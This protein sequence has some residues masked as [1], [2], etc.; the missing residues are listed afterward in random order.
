[1]N[2]QPP[3]VFQR[4][5]GGNAA[6]TVDQFQSDA[7]EIVNEPEPVAAR[8]TLFVLS[9]FVLF[10]LLWS[11]FA[12]IDRIVTARGRVVTVAPTI[13]VQPFES[14]IVK[15][16][17]VRVGDAVK[18][19][20]VLA[21]LDP[22]FALA[23]VGQIEGRVDSLD[24]VIERLQAEHAGRPH[25]L[26]PD[27]G[28]DHDRL[29]YSIWQERQ[30]QYQAQMASYQE[31]ISSATASISARIKER[32]HLRAR[33][34][35]LREVE[36]MRSSLESRQTGSR[37]NV[38]LAR[39]AR[40]DVELS[41]QIAE[42]AITETRH[43]MAALEAERDVFSRG[44]DSALVEELVAKKDERD[45]LNEQL[46]KARRLKDMIELRTP[47]DAV[48]LDVAARS[49]GSV[50][51]SAEPLF[52]LVP[53]DAVLEVEAAVEARQ[54]GYIAVGDPVQIKLEAYPYQEHGMLEGRITTI[55]GDAFSP[56][57]GSEQAAIGSFYRVRVEVTRQDLRNVP[58]SFQL[59]P[60]MPLAAEIK[61]GKRSVISYL[62]R[63]ILR[64]MDE[65]MREP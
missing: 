34:D 48:V 60:G 24:A 44:W 28:N 8:M 11:V 54:L 64:G 3:V 15:S 29:Q 1:M 51:N 20:D 19:N 17:D 45:S 21:R 40:I 55:S 62:L 14:A 58:A 32:D 18:A 25:T 30:T 36:E 23:D 61:I 9:A 65:S 13:V 57:P 26:P 35:V 38:L 56:E 6:L 59:I 52:R 10:A 4:P 47:V 43:A 16:I 12:T 22:T 33:L 42:N 50:V 39:D 27:G 37:L 5:K 7:S 31:K 49:V 63:P 41:L 46:V 2:P 53:Q